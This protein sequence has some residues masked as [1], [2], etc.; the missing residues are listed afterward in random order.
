[1]IKY[2]LLLA[3]ITGAGQDTTFRTTV[4]VVLVPTTVTDRHG[5][6]VNGLT[7]DDFTLLDD[8]HP[9]KIQV[10]PADTVAIPLSLIIL[11]QA[12]NTAPAAIRKIQ[13]I[14]STIQP[15]ITGERG[16]AALL[17]FGTKIDMVQDFTN[18]AERLSDAFHSINIQSGKTARMIDGIAEAVRLFGTRP[19]NEHRVLFVIGE[20]RDR[21]S[22]TRLKDA[23]KRVQLEGVTVFPMIFSAYVTQFTTRPSDLPPPEDVDLLAAL[24][25]PGRFLGK[26][27]AA[28][29]LAQYSGGRKTSFATLQGL[30][31][32]LTSL[33]EELHSQYILSFTNDRC[34]PGLHRIEVNLKAHPDAVVR[35]RYGYWIDQESCRD[36][37][38]PK[39]R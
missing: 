17:A 37:G 29:A 15:L 25:E 26:A 32:I 18:D 21:G 4:P 16:H 11:V 22:A 9:R 10:D 2:L 28:H 12:N 30:E 34:V 35:A 7:L 36:N 5:K 38:S 14:G 1:M 33:G 31:S 8:G 13:K 20:S 39:T 27:D 19:N 23:V 3:A 24:T 6:Y